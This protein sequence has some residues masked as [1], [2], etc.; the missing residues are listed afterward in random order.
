MKSILVRITVDVSNAMQNKELPLHGRA[1]VYSCALL[2]AA[3]A[4][5]VV[6]AL[7]SKVLS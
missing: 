7:V 1:L 5:F 4:F 6:C 2:I 3:L